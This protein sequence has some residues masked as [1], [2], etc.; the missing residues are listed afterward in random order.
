MT[1]SIYALAFGAH[2]DDVEISCAATML[3]LAREQKSVVVCDLTEGEMGTRGTRALRRKEAAAAATALGYKARV[4]LNLGD[5]TFDLSRKNLLK[6]ITVI[7]AYRPLVV[8]APQPVERHP[9]HERAADLVKQACFYAGLRKIETKQNGGRQERH[10]PKF[11][12]HYLQ[13]KFSAPS[14]IVDVSDT[15]EESRAGLLAFKSQ[16][17]N[18]NSKEPESYLT[19][20]E[21]LLA[22]EARATYFGELIGARYGE[23]FLATNPLG[24]PV[25]SDLFR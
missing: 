8:L 6:V 13:D 17:Y 23:G 2:P 12:F 20:K 1:D 14:F 18:P 5:T 22:L 11:L 15:F 4:N 10:R 7:R 9:D 24:V 19:R 3:K 16:F 21:F 25:F